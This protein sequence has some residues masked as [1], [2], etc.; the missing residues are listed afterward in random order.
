[1]KVQFFFKDDGINKWSTTS[2]QAFIKSWERRVRQIWDG[3]ILKGLSNKKQVKLGLAFQ[4]QIGG[5]MFDHWEI[6]VKKVPPGSVFRS[7]V[8]PGIKEVTL[9]END[10]GV[11][12]RKIRTSGNY[13]QITSVHEFG[14]MIG[15][16]DEYG[17]LFGGAAG[18]HNS[19][20]VSLM[21]IGSKVRNRHTTFLL[22]WLN[23]ALTKHNI[24]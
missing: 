17:P 15:L 8:K 12:V 22:K 6:T 7:Y 10:N 20:Y 13:Q 5:F 2:K 24:K 3:H 4:T 16:D 1:M 9:T 14:H 11:T 19:D 18:P 23:N 21:N